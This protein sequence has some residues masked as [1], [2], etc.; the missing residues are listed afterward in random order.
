MKNLFLFGV[1]IVVSAACL[2]AQAPMTFDWV[3]ASDEIVQLDPTDFHAGRVYRPGPAGGNMH[4]I[5]H[6]KRPVTLAMAGA[7]EWNEALPHPET[8]RNLEYRCVRE[9]VVDTIYECHL[10]PDRPMVL[11]LH[12]ERTPDRAIFQGIGAIVGRVGAKQLVSPNEVQITYHSWQCVE[13]CIQPQYQWSRVVKEKYDLG[14]APKLYSVLT[15]EYDG[16]RMWVKIKA[17]MPMTV[18]VLP[19]KAA[20]SGL[21]QARDTFFRPGADHLQTA[22]HPIHG[23]RV[24]DQPRRWPAVVD[25]GAR[26]SGSFPQE[27]G[28]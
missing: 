17:Q 14:S 6:A 26:F 15:P 16:Q 25:R 10:P 28:D 23:V 4:V 19:S 20:G 22:W 1:S 11:V 27:S 8:L 18:A 21:R 3:R 5:I 12:D 9:H 7:R 2:Q 13:N 24:Q